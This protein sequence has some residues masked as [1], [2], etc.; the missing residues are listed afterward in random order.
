[1]ARPRLLSRSS[2]LLVGCGGGPKGRQPW[3]GGGRWGQDRGS[4]S[5]SPH[6]PRVRRAPSG[7]EG[8]CWAPG[9]AAP[10]HNTVKYKVVAPLR[11]NP[12]AA[13]RLSGATACTNPRDWGPCPL[14]TGLRGGE[15]PLERLVASRQERR[16]EG[17]GGKG[18]GTERARRVGGQL[19]G[20]GRPEKREMEERWEGG[21]E[22][23]CER[24]NNESLS[25][26]FGAG[27]LWLLR[28]RGLRTDEQGGSGAHWETTRNMRPAGVTR[29]PPSG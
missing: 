3:V 2:S 7:Q 8:S 20:K 13:R 12:E 18:G 25:H 6:S 22:G 1:M 17:A 11:G 9:A 29:G 21:L 15:V 26:N 10:H 28:G 23:G 16:L 4:Q 5:G 27:T 19:G 14:G 24:V